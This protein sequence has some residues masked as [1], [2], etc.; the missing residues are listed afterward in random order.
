MKQIKWALFQTAF[1]WRL[2]GSGAKASPR[3][4]HSSTRFTQLHLWFRCSVDVSIRFCSLP[5]LLSL[6]R[7]C[8][9]LCYCTPNSHRI[10]VIGC[11]RLWGGGEK[12][13]CMQGCQPEKRL[14]GYPMLGEG[15]NWNKRMREKES[16]GGRKKLCEFV[17]VQTV[18]RS[19]RRLHR[20][21]ALKKHR[22]AFTAS[23]TDQRWGWCSSSACMG[24]GWL[25]GD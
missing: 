24:S 4:K 23:W 19:Q 11:W 7:S 20:P 22:S 10:G 14:S 17:H 8:L 1:C 9:S 3:F 16:E 12:K 25:L 18:L 13:H 2:T 6:S 15:K 5:T 21:V